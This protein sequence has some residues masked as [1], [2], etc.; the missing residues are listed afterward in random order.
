M[1]D[2]EEKSKV[3][4]SIRTSF[5]RD[6]I[7]ACIPESVICPHLKL[8]IFSHK[9]SYLVNSKSMSFNEVNVS[10]EL[11]MA[12]RAPSFILSQLKNQHQIYRELLYDLKQRDSSS[13]VLRF[14]QSWLMLLNAASVTWEHLRKSW[15]FVFKIDIIT[16][17]SPELSFPKNWVFQ[18]PEPAS[19]L[20]SRK[21]EYSFL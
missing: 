12:K 18:S 15:K 16:K 2:Y 6:W 5:P 11:H 9:I 14:F 3:I 4:F 17:K 21:F 10:I 1:S 20:L 13:T 19:A 7:T 8:S